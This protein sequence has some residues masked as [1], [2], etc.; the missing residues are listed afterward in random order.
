MP[1]PQT[2]A[3]TPPEGEAEITTIISDIGAIVDANLI[4]RVTKLEALLDRHGIR[5]TQE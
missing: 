5:Q 2:P 1:E 4:E 3:A